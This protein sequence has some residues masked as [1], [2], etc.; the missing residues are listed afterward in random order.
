METTMKKY[1]AP[2]ILFALL[3]L[4][5]RAQ[6]AKPSVPEIL[7]W[8][9]THFEVA[10][11]S[12]VVTFT[13]GLADYDDGRFKTSITFQGCNVS[14]TLVETH[15]YNKADTGQFDYSLEQTGTATLD[16]SKGL[17]DAITAGKGSEGQPPA[18]VVIKFAQPFAWHQEQRYSAHPVPQDVVDT[19]NF[20]LVQI[21]FATED[22]ANQQARAWHDAIVAC[23][24]KP[25]AH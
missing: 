22:M 3:T 18:H 4:N 16:L 11:E 2:I 24:G 13:G 6:V 5:V 12:T 9:S 23:G 14:I 1:L 8:I 17:P 15:Q 21:D 7:T 19:F 25:S 20:K 10:H